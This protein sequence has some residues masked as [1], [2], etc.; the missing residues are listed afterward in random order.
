MTAHKCLIAL[1]C[2]CL[3]LVPAS[4]ID[5]PTWD[6]DT[7]EPHT[8][9]GEPIYTAH[10]PNHNITRKYE[11]FTVYYD[12]EVLSPRWTA[13]KMTHYVAD[14]NSDIE[15][16]KQLKTDK[17]LKDKGYEVTT[18]DDYNNPKC[19]QTW[20]RGHMVQL[21]DARGYGQTSDDPPS[22]K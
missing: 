13:I 10:D 11:G 2:L 6:N 5:W 15:R 19:K 22:S 17:I 20:D 12:D 18:H 4:A 16:P 14:K 21:D 3:F 8:V 7:S 9:F 1:V